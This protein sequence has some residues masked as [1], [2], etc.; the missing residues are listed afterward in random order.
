MVRWNIYLCE[1]GDVVCAGTVFPHRQEEVRWGSAKKCACIK[2]NSVRAC[3]LKQEP[4]YCHAINTA[5]SRQVL[6]GWCSYC[7]EEVGEPR[8]SILRLQLPPSQ[9]YCGERAPEHL[10][11]GTKKQSKL[12][13]RNLQQRALFKLLNEYVF[14][15]RG[16]CE[17]FGLPEQCYT[18]GRPL[19][20]RSPEQV[21]AGCGKTASQ[22]EG[23]LLHIE[24]QSGLL[25]AELITRITRRKK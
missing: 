17:I 11:V 10:P 20:C 9:L 8:S 19:V 23:N 4:R 6:W 16:C 25:G 1:R 15:G 18:D 21:E 2:K 3:D 22:Q 14:G 13:Q 24:E 5:C 7:G 12:G